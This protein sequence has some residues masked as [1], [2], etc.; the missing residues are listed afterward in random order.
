MRDILL[1]LAPAA[2]A[3]GFLFSLSA[4]VAEQDTTSSGMPNAVLAPATEGDTHDQAEL[5]QVIG[6]ARRDLAERRGIE[7]DSIDLLEAGPVTWRSS[8]IGCP[9]SG[10][11]YTQALVPGYRIVLQV[12]VEAFAYHGR[13]G[14]SPFLCPPNRAETPA[15]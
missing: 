8:A 3:A 1:A 11:Y 15:E 10:V 5:Q 12:G 14:G 13:L 4:C 6:A 9:E 2:F 7:A